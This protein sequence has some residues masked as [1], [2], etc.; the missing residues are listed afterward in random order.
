VVT[1][2]LSDEI[3]FYNDSTCDHAKG[4]TL[5]ADTGGVAFLEALIAVNGV[6]REPAGMVNYP[7]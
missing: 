7:W 3:E 1:F 6:K 4:W 5:N 2:D